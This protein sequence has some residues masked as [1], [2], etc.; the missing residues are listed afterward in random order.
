[1]PRRRSVGSRLAAAFAVHVAILIVLLIFHVGTIRE[2]V[3]AGHELSETS[4]RLYASSTEQVARLDQL[5]E[6]L[7]KYVVTADT[8][9]LAKFEQVSNEVTA[10]LE[11]LA[12]LPLDER[13]RHEL[14]RM[15]DAWNHLRERAR[16]LRQGDVAAP[17]LAD[18]AAVLAPLF[19]V[20]YQRVG[21][22]EAASQ[23]AL[24]DRL[25][26]SADSAARAERVSWAAAAVALLLSILVPGLFVR[27]MSRE[28]KALQAGTRAVARGDFDY[29][30][31]IGRTREFAQLAGDFNTMT[32]RLGELDS[33]QREFL[34]RVSHDLKTPLASMRETVN[35]LLDE[36]AAPLT[37]QQRTL[38]LLNRESG[39]RLAAMIAK[40]LN[41]SALEAGTPAVLTPHDVGDI[42]RSAGHAAAIAGRE[43]GIRVVVDADPDAI[44]RCDAERVRQLFDNLLENALKFSPEGGTIDVSVR[45]IDDQVA[46]TVRDEGP[47]V[48]EEERERIFERFFQAKEGRS[49]PG[50]G[51]GLGLTIC[52]EI[53]HLHGG[54]IGVESSE[55]RGAAFRVLLPAVELSPARS[56]PAEAVA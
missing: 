56:A 27:S 9:Y 1:M 51:V 32:R 35:V 21:S 46:I 6:T 34:S 22:L 47:G 26:A 7:S 33:M 44:V 13:E 52:R 15:E 14:R 41:L 10:S 54:S 30:L 23:A 12:T 16:P 43:R 29:R 48:P 50:R 5:Q 38:L 19:T 42:A 36:I 24:T 45:T 4:A 20:L 40:L 18:S 25:A 31:P 28:L 8:G 39:E 55:G 11:R 3:R 17:F 2:S 37:P 49:V 53:A